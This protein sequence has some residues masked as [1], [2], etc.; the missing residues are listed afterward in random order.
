MIVHCPPI[1]ALETIDVDVQPKLDVDIDIDSV[2]SRLE[3]GIVIVLKITAA[4]IK[5]GKRCS[6][7]FC[8]IAYAYM[9]ALKWAGISTAGLVVG[10]QMMTT[11]DCYA[12]NTDR[13]RQFI[14]AFDNGRVKPGPFSDRVRVRKRM[15]WW[16]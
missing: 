15:E 12:L 2:E 10:S 13:M 8:P 7:A 3:E 9:E 5:W 14:S 6:T 4:H 16:P 11:D 1:I